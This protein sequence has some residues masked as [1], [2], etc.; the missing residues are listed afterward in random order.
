[1]VW[2]DEPSYYDPPGALLVSLIASQ[3]R[4]AAPAS[5]LLLPLGGLLVYAPDVPKALV[6]PP[7]GMTTNG[8]ALIGQQLA[9]T[10]DASTPRGVFEQ[11]HRAH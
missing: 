9:A 8:L 10:R 3:A 2:I 7:K 4:A 1:M 11:A 5:S 6:Y